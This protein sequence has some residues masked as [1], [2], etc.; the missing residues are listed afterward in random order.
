MEV[1]TTEQGEY[2]AVDAQY[3]RLGEDI[4]R[5]YDGVTLVQKGFRPQL[6]KVRNEH[7][8]T[9]RH[10]CLI[11]GPLGHQ[12]HFKEGIELCESLLSHLKKRGANAGEG[13]AYKMCSQRRGKLYN[14][15]DSFVDAEE[16]YIELLL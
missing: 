16:I 9:I 4:P 2:H 8:L 10:Q 5:L 14:Q 3:C 6:E 11:S 13:K 7:D 1:R 12:G 15:Q